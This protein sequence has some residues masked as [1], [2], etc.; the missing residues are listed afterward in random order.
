MDLAL[1]ATEGFKSL[2]MAAQGRYDVVCGVQCWY[3]ASSVPVFNGA[4]ILHDHMLNPDTIRGIEEYF[5]SK[6][7]PYS[8]VTM[9]ALLHEAWRVLADLGY[10]EY[11]RMPAMWLEG[12]P[13]ASPGNGGNPDLWL[14]RVRTQRDL[15]TFRTLLSAIF[16]I[17]REEIELVMGEEA[18]EVPSVRHYVGFVGNEPVGTI[19]NVMNGPVPGIWNVG[20]VSRY[21]RRGIG[22]SMMTSVLLEAAAEG[23]RASMLLASRDGIPLYEQLGYRTLSTVRVFVKNREWGEES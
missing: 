21:R 8:L 12:L 17:T 4:A 3:C 15:A 10:H 9:D 7:R 16:Y 19:T 23:H 22:A 5:T 13:H 20:T 11:E 6:D 14:S 18:L 1:A 2:S